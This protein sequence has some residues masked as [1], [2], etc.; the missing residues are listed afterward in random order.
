MG[1]IVKNTKG[2]GARPDGW[3]GDAMP[4]GSFH[5]LAVYKRVQKVA[6]IKIVILL[7]N[8]LGWCLTG[9]TPWVNLNSW[10]G[11]LLFCLVAI[12]WGQKIYFSIRKSSQ[13]L[14]NRDLS[15]KKKEHDLQRQL[16]DDE[17]KP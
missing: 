17:D 6:E 10:Q 9:I 5:M 8:I 1:T 2:G 15:L 14:K 16:N 7:S 4:L 13:E 3:G 12:F 11:Y